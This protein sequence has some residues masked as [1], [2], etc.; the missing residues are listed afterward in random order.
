MQSWALDKYKKR[1][2]N[3]GL[4]NE[5]EINKKKLDFKKYLE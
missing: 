1:I 3:E 5:D 2:A 4:I